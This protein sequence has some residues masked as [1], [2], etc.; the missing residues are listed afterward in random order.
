MVNPPVDKVEVADVE[1]M[2]STPVKVRLLIERVP[3]L[4]V[5]ETKRSP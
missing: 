4:D 3:R 5:P 1:V 2:S